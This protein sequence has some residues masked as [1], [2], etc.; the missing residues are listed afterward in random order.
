MATSKDKAG[1]RETDDLRR[2]SRETADHLRAL[3]ISLDGHESPEDLVAV[4]EAV[5]LFESAVES[6]GGDLMVD[7]P[8]PGATPQPDDPHFGLP[9]RHDHE[10]IAAYLQ[11]LARATTEVL[12]HH[13][14]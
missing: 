2:A 5:E 14:P 3:G 1:S 4:E 7:E 13:R 12:R 8:P 6:R 9:L 10:S 11:R